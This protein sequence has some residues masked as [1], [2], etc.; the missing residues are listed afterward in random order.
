MQEYSNYIDDLDLEDRDYMNVVR[1]LRKLDLE[2]FLEQYL[3]ISEPELYD[4]L[5]STCKNKSYRK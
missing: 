3:K 1:E 4:K 2:R 5:I